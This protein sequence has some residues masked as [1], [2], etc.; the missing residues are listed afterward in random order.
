V[1]SDPTELQVRDRMVTLLKGIS[2]GGG[3][4]T[5]AGG[6]VYKLAFPLPEM[7][8]NGPQLIAYVDDEN[9]IAGQAGPLRRSATQFIVEGRLK[10]ATPDDDLLK[11]KV[12]V[13]HAIINSGGTFGGIAVRTWCEKVEHDYSDAAQ[14]GLAAFR[15]TFVVEANW[16]PSAP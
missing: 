9:A 16:S 14:S 11:L 1:P 6:Q 8:G 15:A 13:K 10:S 5:N 2:V 4:H 12:D 7:R 3:Y